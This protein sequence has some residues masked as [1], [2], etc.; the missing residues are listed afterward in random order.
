MAHVHNKEFSKRACA[1]TQ[2]LVEWVGHAMVI[3]QLSS[4][5]EMA[6]GPGGTEAGMAPRCCCSQACSAVIR[7]KGARRECAM[8]LAALSVGEVAGATAVRECPSGVG[9]G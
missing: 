5:V 8:R 1:K 3:F 2:E 7:A 6:E 4:L 9:R